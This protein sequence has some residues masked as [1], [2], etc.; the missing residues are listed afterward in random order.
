MKNIIIGVAI[1]AVSLAACN[2][3]SDNFSAENKKMDDTTHVSIPSATEATT[4]ANID[5]K[6]DGAM[7][8]MV[9]Q[10]LQMKNALA[11][12]NGKEAANA[13]NAFVESMGG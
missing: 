12:D 10:Y 8:E 11:N 7:K 4:S 13:G 5:T 2:N 6:V 3:G 9:S 1:S